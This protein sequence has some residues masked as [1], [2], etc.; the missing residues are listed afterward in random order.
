MSKE[1]ALHSRLLVAAARDMLQPIGMVQKGRSRIWLDDHGWWVCVVEFQPSSWS[2]GSYLNVGCM[3]LWQVKE[4]IS[5]D[6]GHR[7]EKFS[8]FHNEEEFQ[9]VA[10][11]LAERAAT[12]V[13][14][15]RKLF[16]NVHDVSGY[17]LSR[18]PEGFWPTFNAAMACA[19]AGRPDDARR[20]FKRI[21]ES[22][23]DDRPWVLSA[24]AEAGR[25][26]LIAEQTE[27]FREV[28]TKTIHRTRDLQK[29]PRLASVSF[30]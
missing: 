22:G 15:Y 25:L 7:V 4:H 26:R 12:E 28:I 19:L 17:Y 2:R 30:D 23:P 29:L 14:R 10:R 9:A 24:Q 8:Q 1:T 5:F 16:L 21:I 13:L 27:Q 11:S 6:E 20:L 18:H 3:W